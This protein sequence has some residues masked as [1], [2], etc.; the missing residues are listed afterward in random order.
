MVQ[1]AGT[2]PLKPHERCPALVHGSP[3]ATPAPVNRPFYRL[4]RGAL[5]TCWTLSLGRGKEAFPFFPEFR[6]ALLS[7]SGPFRINGLR[8]RA[9]PDK[10]VPFHRT[11]PCRDH[12]A[13]PRGRNHPLSL[14]LRESIRP[15]RYADRPELTKRSFKPA[16][17][18][19]PAAS[20]LRLCRHSSWLLRQ[21]GKLVFEHADF[22]PAIKSANPFH[23]RA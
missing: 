13:I 19:R 11:A 4:R 5:A 16:S 6:P 22:P 1:G 21:P 20:R 12:G 15:V 2:R 10:R 8:G 23:K 17:G 14:S 3:E 9:R 7:L 18:Q